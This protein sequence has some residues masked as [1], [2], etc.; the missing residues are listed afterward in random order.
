MPLIFKTKNL[1][2]KAFLI[3][4]ML[5][6]SSALFSAS[7]TQYQKRLLGDKAFDS[8]LY[9]VA[10]NYYENY[11]KDA[12]GDSPAIRDAY[13]CLI[14]TC[15]RA[16]NIEEAKRLYAELSAKFEQ[17]FS[18]H[19]EDQ[20]TLNY[21]KAEIL[22][23][24][25][26]FNDSDK[27]FEEV[28]SDSTSKNDEIYLNA[29]AGKALSILR[30][31]DLRSAYGIFD[32]LR[33][34]AKLQKNKE[35]ASIASQ[36]MIMIDLAT[37]NYEAAK[38][39]IK[40]ETDTAR[41]VD[42]EEFD[43]LNIYVLT[44]EDHLADARVLYNK[45]KP[46]ALGPNYLWFFIAYTLSAS[47]MKTEKYEDA[48]N[49]IDDAFALAP[50]MYNKELITILK[51][52]AY[53]KLNNF[54]QAI[55]TAKMFLET[56]PKSGVNAKIL[57]TL[58][59]ALAK[60]K[61][62]TDIASLSE[63]YFSFNLPVE[64]DTLELASLFGQNALLL[65][66]YP[67]A[68][69]Y[70]DYIISKSKD[71]SFIG[72]ARYYKAEALLAQNEYHSALKEFISIQKT[73]PNL[74][75]E[76]LFKESQIYI[77]I[78]GYLNAEK[79]LK[80]LI[81]KFPDT[82]LEPSPFF[83]HAVTLEKLKDYD[84][85]INEFARFAQNNPKSN[86]APD[87]YYE[88]GSLSLITQKMD[89]AALYFRQIIDNYKDI[90]IAKDAL[91]KLVFAYISLKDID[92]AAKYSQILLNAYTDT[93]YAIQVRFWLSNYYEQN[94]QFNEALKML[95]SITKTTSDADV[96]ARCCY[97]AAFIYSQIGENQKAIEDINKIE[98][99]FPKSQIISLS[100]YLKGDILSSDAKYSEAIQA[101]QSAY[102]KSNTPETSIA[103]L[104][105]I[106]DCYFAELNYSQDKKNI[107]AS[108]ILNYK[109][110]MAYPE[111]SIFIKTQTLYK[112]GK[113]YEISG[114]K[115]KAIEAYHE[116]FYSNILEMEKG[117]N[118]SKIWLVKSAIALTRLL[119]DENTS[120]GAAAAIK[121]LNE[122]VKY[123]IAPVTDFEQRINEIKNLYKLKE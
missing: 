36:E 17:F 45:I 76:S 54:D 3:F 67:L 32:K 78:D 109:K 56:F 87:A 42:S 95:D 82:K 98:T 72:K 104:G 73:Y 110:V 35:L 48:L 118:P 121:V 70:F 4:S 93:Q 37:N 46:M 53:I 41:I 101:Y 27:L 63:K 29:M 80:V 25:G 68:N 16:N 15:L 88:A 75:E 91:Y 92:N 100:L 69:Q 122:L 39:I 99:Q 19:P 9:D 13:Y 2:L 20:R 22:L 58:A 6:F 115:E 84:S 105:R 107:I 30:M 21:W 112:L 86:L 96:I 51:I 10:M 28:L 114:D 64:P 34:N 44:M 12:G 24:E 83:M 38:A 119:Q 18:N 61:R 1:I 74:E 94:R 81:E 57:L 60:E 79:T 7:I 71:N 89:S 40:E 108:A 116:A 26:K 49:M 11:L 59:E 77:K 85:A 106:G 90:P 23:Y 123:N 117:K 43:L 14:S 33:Q 102:D 47:Y 31:G 66:N 97:R 103:S 5:G 65:A 55:V 120:E 50:D 113:C 111:I 52:N 8:G 62:N